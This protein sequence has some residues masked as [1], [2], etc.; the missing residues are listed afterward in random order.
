M[1]KYS[2]DIPKSIFEGFP[3]LEKYRTFKMVCYWDKG[4]YILALLDVIPDF[5]NNI[6]TGKTIELPLQI[7]IMNRNFTVL[8][9]FNGE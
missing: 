8:V 4:Y 7:K 2:L 6:L 3:S 5:R 1:K 9:T